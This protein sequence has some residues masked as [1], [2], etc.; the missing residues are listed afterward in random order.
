MAQPM[1]QTA[2]IRSQHPL[3]DERDAF[4]QRAMLTEILARVSHEA[5]QGDTLEAMMR[6]IVDCITRRL[7]VT[8]ASIILLNEER[9]HFVQEAWARRI[10]LELPGGMPRPVE[11]GAAGPSAEASPQA[12]IA[13]A[14]RALYAAKGE[15]RDCVAP[16][17]VAE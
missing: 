14:D 8:I 5:L 1:A 12:L 3:W 7:P 6:A 10:E 16:A 13:A 4:G 11:L 2:D 17:S 9:T 15:G